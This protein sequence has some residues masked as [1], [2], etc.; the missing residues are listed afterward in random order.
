MKLRAVFVF[1]VLAGV[2]L[3]QGGL[4]QDTR[5]GTVRL[6]FT[7]EQ[8]RGLQPGRSGGG[9]NMGRGEWLQGAPGKRNGLASA[10]GI[11]FPSVHADVTIDDRTLRDVAI[12]YKGNGTYLEG[13]AAGKFSYKIDFNQFVK[14]QNLGEWAS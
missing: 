6:A 2:C 13:Q 4:F 7:R 1:P 12:R 8:W 10:M 5:V 11:E 14:G 3:A 9:M